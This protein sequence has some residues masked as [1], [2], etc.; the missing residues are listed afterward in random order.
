MYENQKSHIDLSSFSRSQLYHYNY[1]RVP[2]GPSKGG[3]KNPLFSKSDKSKYP[4]FYKEE[5]S[6]TTVKAGKVS[7]SHIGPMFSSR[8]NPST[9]MFDS[10]LEFDSKIRD[11]LYS[12]SEN[13]LSSDVDDIFTPEA[14]P[15]LSENHTIDDIM[16]PFSS[17]L[18]DECVVDSESLDIEPL[19]L[20][21]INCSSI[22]WMLDGVDSMLQESTVTTMREDVQSMLWFV[23]VIFGFRTNIYDRGQTINYENIVSFVFR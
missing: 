4:E 6:S 16:D 13:D 21:D 18:D 2:A 12:E 1:I 19:S 17:V 7:S 23:H 5:K 8:S 15:C 9:K 14:S 3:Y 22:E 10:I 11:M 20:D